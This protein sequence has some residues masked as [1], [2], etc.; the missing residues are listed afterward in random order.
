L[1]LL[2][3]TALDV[4]R[5][6]VDSG[7]ADSSTPSPSF[8]PPDIEDF[9]CAMQKRGF[10]IEEGEDEG[11]IIAER[12]QQR[13]DDLV[14]GRQVKIV[15]LVLS[16]RC[17]FK[18]TYCFEGLGATPLSETIYANSSAERLHAQEADDNRTMKKEH[19]V[20]YLEECIRLVRRSGRDDLHVQLFGGEPLVNWPTIRHVLD[21]IGN[22][23]KDGVSISYSIIT[24]GSLVTEDVSQRFKEFEIPVVVSYDS[25]S[26]AA[27]PL[28][29]GRDSHAVIRRGLETLKR[30]GNRVIL[31]AALTESTFAQF[32]TDLVDFAFGN[33]IYEV[34]VV[35]DLDSTFY[36]RRSPQEIVEKLWSVASYAR[37]KGVLV[38]GYWH[39]IFQGIIDD[40]R[41][42]TLG[43]ANCSAMGVQFSVEPSGDVF[44]CKASGGY[45]GNIMRPDELLR[46]ETY[47][48]YAMRACTT[49][50][51]CRRCVIEHFC[52]G[53][54]LG[55]VENNHGGNIYAVELGA[56]DAY[57]EITRRFIDGV[58]PRQVDT[59]YLS[60]NAY[61]P[62]PQSVG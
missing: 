2:D 9:L 42:A 47:R 11:R 15:Q 4:L 52:G 53:M 30:F 25:P 51:P 56:C 20:A 33:G 18:C 8:D 45:F 41:Y 21:V 44:S 62:T 36:L 14:T 27:R 38:T 61:H 29:G 5:G 17:N 24:N 50:E 57:R 35:L 46:S 59:F 34:G 40:N 60:Q 28:S 55:P 49:P 58:T 16:N 19:A 32:N 43:F 6:F 7:S 48:G 26:S 39:Q 54:C 22:G 23:Q 31:N 37:A 1:C 13:E 3:E 10:L 12:R